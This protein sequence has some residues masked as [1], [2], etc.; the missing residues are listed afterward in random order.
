[1]ALK[2]RCAK[3]PR[4]NGK[5]APPASCE[6]CQYLYFTRVKALENHCQVVETVVR[7]ERVTHNG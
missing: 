4:Y 3:H 6:P 7:L 1:M 2:L 5:K